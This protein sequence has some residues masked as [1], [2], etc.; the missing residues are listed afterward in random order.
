MAVVTSSADGLNLNAGTNDIT[1]TGTITAGATSL[2]G[3]AIT[4]GS[5][6]ALGAITVT[7]GDGDVSITEAND[8]LVAS[9]TRSGTSNS[10][11]LVATSGNITD[12]SDDAEDI[13]S[14]YTLNATA[15]GSIALDTNVVETSLTS[16]SSGTVTIDETNAVTL[17]SVSA[18]NGF[19]LL[20]TSPSPRDGLLSRMPSSA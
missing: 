6:N 1:Q 14:V 10:V 7:S 18:Q 3:S 12:D 2:T 19:C 13:V 11:S 17:T 20:Y 8:V 9:I 5:A 15:T 16:S 4:L